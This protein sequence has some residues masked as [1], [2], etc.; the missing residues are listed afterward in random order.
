[1]FSVRQETCHANQTVLRPFDSDNVAPPGIPSDAVTFMVNDNFILLFQ[2]GS[3]T[4]QK[5]G[6]EGDQGE[7]RSSL[8]PW[9][10]VCEQHWS[11]VKAAG[12]NL[13]S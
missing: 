11:E 2:T 12:K 1:M 5:R 9:S 4:L 3:R 8:K 13:S 10:I 7:T 6:G